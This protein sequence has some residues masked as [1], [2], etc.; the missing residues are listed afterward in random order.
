MT[1]PDAEYFDQWYS[2][3]STSPAHAQIAIR[4][5]GLP[6]RLESTS[7][8]SWD[9][10]ADVVDAIDVDPGDVLVDLACGRGGYGLEIAHRTGASLIGVDFSAIAIERARQ[11]GG[12]RAEFRVGELTATGLPDG[13]A[14]AVVCIDAMQF[15]DPY[16]DGIGEC[17]RILAPGGRLVLTGWDPL[18]PGDEQLPARVRRDIEAA[19]QAAGFRDVRVRHMP[20]WREAERRHWDLAVDLDPNGDPALESLHREGNRTLPWLDRSRRVLAVGVAP[21]SS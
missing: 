10:I 14:S 15:A 8:L 21:P 17:R 16:E 2:A 5:L 4:A 20:A 19:L 11:K 6:P 12:D 13:L 18:E 7:L 3:M 1:V 9:G